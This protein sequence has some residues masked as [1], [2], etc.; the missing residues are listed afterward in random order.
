MS[1]GGNR[2][3]HRTGGEQDVEAKPHRAPGPALDGAGGA[4]RTLLHS[5]FDSR[6]GKA[7]GIRTG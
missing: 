1:A 3:D 4:D 5:E 7:V 2:S 6:H